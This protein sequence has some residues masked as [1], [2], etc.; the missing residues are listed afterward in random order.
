[1]PRIYTEFRIS[2]KTLED[3][4]QYEQK[5]DDALKNAGY[6]SRSEWINEKY[7][8]LIKITS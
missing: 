8:E 3:K 7:R 1:M 5:L 6:K 4:K 2:H